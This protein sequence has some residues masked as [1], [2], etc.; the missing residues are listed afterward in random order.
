M[1]YKKLGNSEIEVSLISLGTMTWGEQNTQ[2]EA[3]EQMD[4]ALDHGVNFWD[5]AEMYP[6][7]VKEETSGDTERCIG[8][9]FEKNGRRDEVVLATKITG[10]SDRLWVRGGTETRINKAQ[11]QLAIEESL[12]RLKTDYIDLYQVHWPDRKMG[13]WGEGAGSYVHKD[14]L[15]ETPIL[16]ALETLGDLVQSGKIR[17]VGVSNE[18]PWGMAQ[19]LDASSRFDLP[20]VVSIQNSYSLLN[21]IYEM[22]LSEYSFR[23]DIGLLAYSPLA[24][25]TLSG[26]Y[27]NGQVPKGSRLALFPEFMTR[28]ETKETQSAI[29]DYVKLAK[30]FSLNP[31][32]MALAFVN[33]RPFVTSNIIGAT[34]IEQLKQNIDSVGVKISEELDEK[35]E[36]IHRRCKNPAAV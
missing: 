34:T 30:D 3:F 31:T 24:M 14:E 20:R 15:D 19:Y 21:R 17:S 26:K 12:K 16:E 32:Q 1:K 28:Y 10:R 29:H 22:G 25:G 33:S 9:W 7:P 5:G 35:I 11:I 2:D 23:E 4:F 6:V 13:L 27:E 8:N 36:E 18:T